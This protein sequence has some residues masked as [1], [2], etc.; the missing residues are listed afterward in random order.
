M[1]IN[2]STVTSGIKAFDPFSSCSFSLVYMRTKSTM[3]E[4]AQADQARELKDVQDEVLEIRKE[5]KEIRDFKVTSDAKMDKI[6]GM[7]TALGK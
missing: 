7:I 1:L 5:M 4:E 3:A 2:N 6:M